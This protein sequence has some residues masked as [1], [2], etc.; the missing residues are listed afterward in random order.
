MLEDPIPSAL[1]YYLG[2]TDQLIFF[3]Q[4]CPAGMLRLGQDTQSLGS[5]VSAGVSTAALVVAIRA[6]QQ[7]WRQ[8]PFFK[9][10]SSSVV[11][12]DAKKTAR[13][14]VTEAVA[15]VVAFNIAGLSGIGGLWAENG[16]G[17]NPSVKCGPT[18]RC[19]FPGI[20]NTIW[21]EVQNC[22]AAFSVDVLGSESTEESAS[23]QY[24]VRTTSLA[25]G[26]YPFTMHFPVNDN[27]T[28]SYVA[29][30]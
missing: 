9:T 14:V 19:A 17:A 2:S 6:L 1:V 21:L 25:E 13:T 10:F 22:T 7:W 30:K 3:P 18:A 12:L 24:V 15:A 29:G 16:L 27:R 23:V 28:W 26:T 20:C 11:K 5:C 8:V 4:T